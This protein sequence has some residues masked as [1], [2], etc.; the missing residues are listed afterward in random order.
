M[1]ARLVALESSTSTLTTDMSSQQDSSVLINGRIEVLEAKEIETDDM[2][3]QIETLQGNMNTHLTLIQQDF[4]ALDATFG[5]HE[6]KAQD[7]DDR[8]TAIEDD[9]NNTNTRI[10]GVDVNI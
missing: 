6:G 5:T 3:N 9:L 7:L 2:L 4:D 10:D 8:I 1:N